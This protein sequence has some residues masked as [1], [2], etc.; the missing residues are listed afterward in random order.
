MSPHPTAIP[1]DT[2]PEAWQLQ[3]EAIPRRSTAERIDEWQQLNRG[4]IKML[5]QAVRRRHPEYD[6]RQVFLAMVRRY[7][8]D[9]L[10]LRVW[11]EAS[12]VEK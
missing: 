4:V 7:H 2:T 5:E 11:P 8:G 3:M 12:S 6:D 1:A 9:Q 10:A